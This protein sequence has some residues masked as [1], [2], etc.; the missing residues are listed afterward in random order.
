MWRRAPVDG[1]CQIVEIP[2]SHHTHHRNPLKRVS[3]PPRPAREH[4]AP[5]RLLNEQGSNGVSRAPI[6]RRVPAPRAAPSGAAPAAERSGQLPVRHINFS[7][8]SAGAVPRPAVRAAPRRPAAA[9]PLPAAAPAAAGAGPAPRARA[10]A[11]AAAAAGAAPAGAAV[12]RPVAGAAI[13]APAGVD[14][15]TITSPVKAARGG[16]AGR[17]ASLF[18]DKILTT[19]EL[20]DDWTE[21]LEAVGYYDG[22]RLL[23]YPGLRAGAAGVGGLAFT[24]AARKLALKMQRVPVTVPGVT[25]EGFRHQLSCILRAIQAQEGELNSLMAGGTPAADYDSD[26]PRDEAVRR[27]RAEPQ[28]DREARVVGELERCVNQQLTQPVPTVLQ[29]CYADVLVFHEA[30]ARE[31]S[32]LVPVSALSLESRSGRTVGGSKDHK[33]KRNEVFKHP[34]GRSR[35]AEQILLRK[36][37]RVA[38]TAGAFEAGHHQLVEHDYSSGI[39][40]ASGNPAALVAVYE[41]VHTMTEAACAEMDSARLDG[42]QSHRYVKDFVESMDRS[43]NRGVTLTEAVKDALDKELSRALVSSGRANH[44]YGR[45]DDHDGWRS[46]D[47]DSTSGEDSNS[48]SEPDKS[49]LRKRHKARS[50]REK[51]ET[52]KL[53]SALQKLISK[54]GSSGG[55]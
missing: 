45:R 54:G 27:G 19:E 44:R 11:P 6:Q 51:G 48:S 39:D 21:A 1:M 55:R 3:M 53:V 8:A 42:V 7:E 34:R 4:R 22:K 26:A 24:E 13:G 28:G 20:E 31:P 29:P 33:H 50:T 12:G 32:H 14:D 37:M 43:M 18:M 23:N 5:N 47:D 35:A 15:A 17:A 25:D 38:A 10:A 46:S 30:L 36:Y 52:S 2:V 40:D 9:D 41:P 49:A 16:D